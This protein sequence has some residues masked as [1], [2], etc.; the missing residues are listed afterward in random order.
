M[1]TTSKTITINN[2]KYK[3][4]L[5]NIDINLNNNLINK[6][7]E[8]QIKKYKINFN[9]LNKNEDIKKETFYFFL[10]NLNFEEILL[11][12][13]DLYQNSELYSKFNNKDVLIKIKND[14]Y[15]KVDFYKLFIEEKDMFLN[16]SLINIDK[17]KT[18]ELNNLINNTYLNDIFK[19]NEYIEQIML[20]EYINDCINYFKINLTIKNE[21]EEYLNELH[22]NIYNLIEY[23]INKNL[24]KDFI[25]IYKLILM[26]VK[27][28]NN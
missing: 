27:E 6:I 16:N 11:L 3:I 8:S 22:K 13:F 18:N 12:E 19:E 23:I 21:F 9:E 2:N 25:Y 17:L 15:V 5:N 14:G 10:N 1:K 24:D 26:T 20:N 7:I 28:I 4:L